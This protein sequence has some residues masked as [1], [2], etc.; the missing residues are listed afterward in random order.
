MLGIL[1]R[2]PERS[3]HVN[4][5]I[6]LARIGRG[7]VSRELLRL[8]R[9]RLATVTRAGKRKLYQANAKSALFPELR[10]LV[11]KTL[12]FASPI[13][14][15]LGPLGE[16]LDLALIYGSVANGSDTAVSDIDLLAVSDQLGSFA[17]NEP[18]FSVMH[19]L[20]RHIEVQHY[21]HEEFRLRNRP[22]DCFLGRILAGPKIF[23]VG[24]MEIVRE[25][26]RT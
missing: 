2:E 4:E 5:I 14:D 10:G 8:E 25:I 19:E 12:G 26:S 16:K 3:F 13:R 23:L 21:T 17:I 6:E 15:A 11:R 7:A 1:F 18:L 20:G 24:S 9:S 22:G